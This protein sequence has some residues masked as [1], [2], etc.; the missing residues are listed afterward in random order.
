MTQEER[1]STELSVCTPCHGRATSQH[2]APGATSAAQPGQHRLP[3]TGTGATPA[4]QH[5]A[6]GATPAP[7]HRAPRQHRLPSTGHRGNTGSPASSLSRQRFQ[8]WYLTSRQKDQITLQ[9]VT[10]LLLGSRVDPAHRAPM[11]R[12]GTPAPQPWQYP[13]SPPS[14]RDLRSCPADLRS[15]PADLRSSPADL[16]SS[17]A[18]LRSSP[19]DLRP[20]LADGAQSVFLA[21]PAA[22]CAA[23]AGPVAAAAALA[24]VARSCLWT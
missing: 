19:A 17:P 21:S 1:N 18:D 5:G 12:R 20:S 7:Q 23:V 4:A 13:L 15:P 11:L 10:E 3:S 16:R 2:E 14:G 6:P 9:S 22:G 8:Y 24:R